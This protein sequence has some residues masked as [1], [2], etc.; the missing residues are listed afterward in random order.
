MQLKKNHLIIVQVYRIALNPVLKRSFQKMHDKIPCIGPAT[1][2]IR[3]HN[4]NVIFV[5]FIGKN[6]SK[7]E[8]IFHYPHSDSFFLLFYII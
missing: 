8:N 3:V 2:F 5:I 7:V 4:L 1:K 6:L